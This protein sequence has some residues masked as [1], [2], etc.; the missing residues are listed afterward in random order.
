MTHFSEMRR[1]FFRGVYAVIA[2]TLVSFIFYD[3]IMG[4][5][6]A[7]APDLN[8]QT[9]TIMEPLSIFFRVSLASGVIIA[10]PFLTYQ[11][12]A[13]LAPAL[14]SKEKRYVYLAVPFVSGLFMVGVAFAYYVAMPPAFRF[15]AQFGSDFMEIQPTIS[16]YIN[17]VTRLMIGIGLSF[18]TPLVIMVMARLGVVSPQWLASKRKAW[19]VIAFVLGALITPTFDPINQTIVAAPLVVLY[20]ISIWL[21]KLVYKKKAAPGAD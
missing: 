3:Q 4:F 8:L 6:T 7:P 19:L 5:L 9:V 15:F 11:L 21:S 14:T 10:M 2:A 20:E 12:F 1:R 17:V 18:E 16:S 13:F